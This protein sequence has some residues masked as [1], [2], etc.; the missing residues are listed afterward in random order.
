M[1]VCLRHSWFAN[2][3][4]YKYFEMRRNEAFISWKRV[5]WAILLV[6][7]NYFTEIKII[8]EDY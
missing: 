2:F 6:T 5:G 1:V 7:M 3:P 8:K 4:V